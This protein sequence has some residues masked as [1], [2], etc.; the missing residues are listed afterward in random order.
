MSLTPLRDP[1]LLLGSFCSSALMKCL[2]IKLTCHPHTHTHKHKYDSVTY[3][4]MTSILKSL[5]LPQPSA[6]KLLCLKLPWRVAVPRKDSRFWALPWRGKFH[7]LCWFSVYLHCLGELCFFTWIFEDDVWLW[8][9]VYKIVEKTP[10]HLKLSIVFVPAQ[11]Q[12]SDKNEWGHNLMRVITKCQTIT[13]IMNSS[14][15][16]PWL[17]LALISSW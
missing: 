3:F 15:K 6:C 7:V 4:P 2:T 14:D 5:L 8:I 1:S 17:L 12:L 13:F 9:P 10:Q 11:P 16:L